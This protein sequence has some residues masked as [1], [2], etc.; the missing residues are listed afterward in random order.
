MQETFEGVLNDIEKQRKIWHQEID[1]LVNDL[2]N[3]VGSIRKTQMKA[4]RDH[5]K[6]LQ[7]LLEDASQSIQ[8]NKDLL[9]SL[10]IS[11][12]LSYESMNSALKK[13]PPKLEISVPRFIPKATEDDLYSDKIGIIT[14]FCISNQDGGYQLKSQ[15]G[16][17]S[18]ENRDEEENEEDLPKVVLKV[19]QI[20]TTIE[21]EISGP[22]NAAMIETFGLQ[23]TRAQYNYLRFMRL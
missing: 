8:R 18:R 1:I 14:G 13:F 12:S 15:S 23:V 4:Q 16:V 5:L 21:T 6:R 7:E 17:V 2:K 9:E 11:K 3:D 19:P 20:I 10:E 22:K